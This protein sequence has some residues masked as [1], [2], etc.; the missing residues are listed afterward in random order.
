MGWSY[1]AKDATKRFSYKYYISTLIDSKKYELV[2]A[3][4]VGS[5][6]YAAIKRLEDGHVIGVVV[7]LKINKHE[8]GYKMITEDMGPYHCECPSVIL[9]LLSDT[10][11]VNA[12]DWRDDCRARAEKARMFDLLDH[13]DVIVTDKPVPYGQNGNFRRFVCVDKKKNHWKAQN[14]E[15]SMLVKFTKNN[16]LDYH[17][18]AYRK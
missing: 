14:S 18:S 16:A 4:K 15:T 1:Q 8:V 7:L 6:A 11:D 17:F 2:D 12:N 13:G 9:D 5:T 3:R 10:D